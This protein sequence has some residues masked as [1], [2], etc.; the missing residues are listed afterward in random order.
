MQRH[1]FPTLWKH[2][3]VLITKSSWLKLVDLTLNQGISPY[4]IDLTSN[5][6]PNHLQLVSI[7]VAS[8]HQPR[9]CQYPSNNPN[10]LLLFH[11][12]YTL[13]SVDIC[14]W[15]PD[16]EFGFWFWRNVS[17]AKY[18]IHWWWSLNSSLLCCLIFCSLRGNKISAKGVCA[19]VRVFQVNQSLQKL[20]L[21]WVQPFSSSSNPVLR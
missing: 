3:A 15:R 19:L 9:T 10:H 4:H 13:C 12:F 16:K 18:I 2:L 11:S 5:L 17:L 1:R 21:E 7:S 14:R 6:N 8:L 20:K